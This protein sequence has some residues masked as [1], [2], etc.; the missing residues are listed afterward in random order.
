MESR[1]MTVQE[2]MRMAKQHFE[3]GNMEAAVEIYRQV[4]EGLGDAP[5]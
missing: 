5:D 3:Y 4:L 1:D 2:A